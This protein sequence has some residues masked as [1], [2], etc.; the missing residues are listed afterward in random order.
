L[1]R[2]PSPKPTLELD[3]AAAEL[4]IPA[5]TII[6]LAFRLPAEA[7]WSTPPRIR[8]RRADLDTWRAALAA[9]PAGDR[10]PGR[11]LVRFLKWKWGSA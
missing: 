9:R 2:R 6:D 10:R 11:S 5:T 4:G 7:T 3:E 8:I 1:P